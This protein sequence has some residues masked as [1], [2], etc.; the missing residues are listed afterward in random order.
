MYGLRMTRIVQRMISPRGRSAGA[1]VRRTRP[2][3]EA[4]EARLVLSS[5]GN[6][7]Y[8]QS[9]LVSDIQGTANFTD[10]NLKDPWGISFSTTSPF[11]ISDQASNFQ[12]VSTKNF[13]PVSTLYSSSGS[14]VPLI[15][16]I[17]NQNNAPANAA[18]NGPTGQVSTSAPGI[19]TSSTD[20][21]VAGPNGGTSHE[22]SFIFANMDGSIS[23]WAGK[24]SGTPI[25][26]TTATIVAKVA[27][28]SFTGLAIANNPAAAV[29][30]ASGIQIYAADQNSGNIDV[31]N[32]KWADDREISRTPMAFPAGYTAF[33]VQNLKGQ[34]YVTYTNQSI[35]SGGI[36][37][38]FKPDGTF[39]KTL[40]ND[41]T[42]KWLDNPW[43][44][45]IAPQS[46]GKFGGDLLVGNNG[47][48]GWI[49]AFDPMNGD[50]KGV[51][52]LASG[53]PFS[54]NNLW[55]LS[56]GNG[57]S[58][59]VANTLYFTAGPGGTDGL[60]GS[61]QAIPSLSAKAPIVPNLPNGAFQTVTTVPANGDLNPYGVAF[62]PPGFPS[63]GTLSPGDIL[64]SNFNNVCQPTGDRHDDRRHQRPNGGQS[65]LLPGPVHARP[66]RAD[67]CPGHPAARLR[68]R[69]QRPGDLRQPGQP[70]VRR[71]GIPHDP[72]SQRQRRHHDQRFHAPRRSVGPDRQR[73]G[74]PRP[75]VC[76]QR[77]QRC[78]DA[79]RPHD[80][81]RRRSDH[82]E[83][84]ADRFGVPHSHRPGGARGRADRTGLQ[85]QERHPLCR[86][87][88]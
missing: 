61:L 18:T 68:D 1:Q 47:G 15:V 69:R 70:G 60:F 22:A 30:G 36:V 11:W 21:Q 40:I 45:T 81:E 56:F 71:P 64:V 9:N 80:P 14:P 5:S 44:L 72:R 27:G 52:T 25:A 82:R 49:N 4:L 12:N 53:Q 75:G 33:N 16:N 8:L 88:G 10:S 41:P 83:P 74:E 59:G 67:H 42:G 65:T 78:G 79:D 58:G 26:N 7:L 38:E 62:V 46:F 76:L 3:I 17:P 35:P 6:T 57:G 48:N 66:A 24:N 50:F 31:F 2:R 19:T 85:P 54:E 86:L 13:S 20:F 87:D 63:G 28:A 77:A 23:A 84:D 51:L 43:G 32:S 29:N 34:L 37:D 73:P 39:V 55:A